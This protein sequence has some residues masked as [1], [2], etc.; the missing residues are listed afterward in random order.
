MKIWML[1]LKINKSHNLIFENGTFLTLERRQNKTEADRTLFFPTITD[2]LEFTDHG[3]V[4]HYVGLGGG[5]KG[6]FQNLQCPHNVI[7]DKG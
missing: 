5:F 4:C 3:Q 7:R 1:R 2:K 6:K